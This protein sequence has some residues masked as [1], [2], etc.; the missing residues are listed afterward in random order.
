MSISPVSGVK[1]TLAYANGN[2][3]PF[4]RYEVSFETLTL[5]DGRQFPIWTT[6]SAGTSEVVH[7]VSNPDKAKQKSTA[8]PAAGNAKREAKGKIVEGKQQVQ[9]TWQKVTAPGRV[10][11]IKQF[12]FSQSPYRRQYLE[13]G[14]RFVADLDAPLD[15]GETSRTGAQLAAVGLAPAPDSTQR[16]S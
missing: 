1:R 13:P 12:I 16:A 11:R 15:F 3:S 6:V 10:H 2:F 5:P 7:L 9:E 8:G 14:T 4:H